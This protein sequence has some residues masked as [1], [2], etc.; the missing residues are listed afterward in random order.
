[1]GAITVTRS[2]LS[3]SGEKKEMMSSCTREA[4]QG[5]YENR[6]GLYEAMPGLYE[7]T[8]GLYEAV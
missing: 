8:Q 5:L 2:A 4:V 1:M 3:A 6:Q 7:A